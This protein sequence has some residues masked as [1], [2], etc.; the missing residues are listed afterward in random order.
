MLRLYVC[1]KH[2]GDSK[3]FDIAIRVSNNRAII[4]AS[5][6]QELVTFKRI[7]FEFENSKEMADS[8]WTV[9]ELS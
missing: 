9:E 5:D 3:A 1:Y 8:G 4:I 2:L 6:L 7:S